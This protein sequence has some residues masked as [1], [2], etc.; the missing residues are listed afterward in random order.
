MV[1]RVLVG[2]AAVGIVVL[3]IIFVGDVERK[4]TSGESNA[5]SAPQQTVAELQAVRF[6][7]EDGL[8]LVGL[9]GFGVLG[10]LA[11]LLPGQETEPLIPP[12]PHMVVEPDAR[13]EVGEEG[14]LCPNCGRLNPDTR[15]TCFGCR[16]ARGS[17]PVDA[18]GR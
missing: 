8:I 13:Q 11:L 6:G 18:G 12:S 10:A 9:I 1:R 7:V 3:A 16:A 5:Q 17:Q 4:A 2:L 15:T 14:W